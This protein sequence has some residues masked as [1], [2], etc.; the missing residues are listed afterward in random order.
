MSNHNLS[1]F[2]ERI[3]QAAELAVAQFVAEWEKSPYLWLQEIDVQVDLVA[4]IKRIIASVFTP[5]E[6][7]HSMTVKAPIRNAIGGDTQ[8]QVL[9]RVTCEPYVAVADKSSSY[10]PDIVIWDDPDGKSGFINDGRWPIIWAC[11]IK[12]KINYYDTSDYGR[13]ESLVT[14]DH[15]LAKRGHL[16]SLCWW[17]PMQNDFNEHP[18]LITI[19]LKQPANTKTNP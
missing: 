7:E 12:Y 9:S 13:L 17:R 6:L 11:E 15:P 18:D 10:K 8:P 19:T 2:Q 16:L 4:R 3:I 1:L 5:Q 14:G